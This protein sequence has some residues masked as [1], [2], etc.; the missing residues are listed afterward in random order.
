[1]WF[2]VLI[3]SLKLEMQ[4]WYWVIFTIITI[5]RPLVWIIDKYIEKEIEKNIKELENTK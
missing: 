4:T 1:M 2:L 3:L 5:L